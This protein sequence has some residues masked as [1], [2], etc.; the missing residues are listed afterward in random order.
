MP[1]A[2]PTTA[3][4][5]IEVPKTDTSLAEDKSTRRFVFWM[6]AATVLVVLVGGGIIYWQVG[7]YVQQSNKNKAQDIEI[8]D[9][10]TKIKNLDLLKPNYEKIIANNGSGSSDA[11]LILRALPVGKGYDELV[12]MIEKMAQGSGVKVTSVTQTEATEGQPTG[13]G[14]NTTTPIP[15]SFTVTLEGGYASILDFLKK[16]E[17]SAR[18]INFSS[19]NITGNS[20][21]GVNQASITMQTYYQPQA[22]INPKM[23]PLQ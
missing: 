19:M 8:G 5:E 23:E 13:N 10:N 6:I 21:N 14:D 4:K 18:V 9:L 15:Y 17:N 1:D 12:A 20:N 7:L 3:K 11:D 22:N 16:T 2:K